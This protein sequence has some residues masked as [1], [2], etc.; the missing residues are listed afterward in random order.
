MRSTAWPL[1][2]RCSSRS[3]LR[4]SP[5]SRAGSFW[6]SFSSSREPS[7]ERQAVPRP[8]PMPLLPKERGRPSGSA[9]RWK[10]KR[11]EKSILQGKERFENWWLRAPFSLSF[12]CGTCAMLPLTWTLASSFSFLQIKN[13]FFW[14]TN[15][16]YK[17]P[18]SLPYNLLPS[19]HSSVPNLCCLCFVAML[20]PKLICQ[21]YC[22]HCCYMGLFYNVLVCSTSFW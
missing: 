13:R 3:K 21:C 22:L 4:T 5:P 14:R 15:F 8:G 11:T 16:H 12:I 18:S 17:V 19:H 7:I 1:T 9:G 10:K 6:D 2:F 20:L